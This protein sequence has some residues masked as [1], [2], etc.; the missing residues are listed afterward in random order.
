MSEVKHDNVILMNEESRTIHFSSEINKKSAAY[1]ISYVEELLAKST[2]Y[3]I[4]IRITSLGGDIDPSFFIFDFLTS[5][6]TQVNTIACGEVCSAGVIAYL[7]GQLRLSYEHSVF[8]IH[9]F[10][11]DLSGSRT[12]N[13]S[14]MKLVEKQS[15]EFLK[16]FTKYTKYNLKTLTSEINNKGE[17]WLTASEAIQKGIVHKLIK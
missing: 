10:Q 13:N 17:I 16:I 6:K 9:D 12:E 15:K 2:L 8:M 3:P 5:L 7:G 11:I 1:L 14:Y 4:N